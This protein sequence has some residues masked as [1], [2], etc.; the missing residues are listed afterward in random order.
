MSSSFDEIRE[1]G[2]KRGK[3]E[4]ESMQKG[5]INPYSSSNPRK[6]EKGRFQVELSFS[7]SSGGRW[8]EGPARNLRKRKKSLLLLILLSAKRKEDA[9][10]GEEGKT[11]LFRR[12]GR[13]FGG[14]KKGKGKERW[15]L[16][17]SRT[18]FYP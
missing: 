9:P 3:E 8:G 4:N 11:D 7:P 15:D 2:G 10:A 1:R 6:K 18:F 16:E 5:V 14:E 17:C 13:I 12:G